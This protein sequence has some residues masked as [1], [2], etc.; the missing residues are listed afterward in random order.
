MN[1]QSHITT[2]ADVKAFFH[3][4][5][6]ERKL[7]FHPDDDFADYISVKEGTPTFTNEEVTVYNRLME[8][9]F[10]VCDA[11]G[12]DIYELGFEELQTIVKPAEAL[13]RLIM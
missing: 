9:S 5:V 2:V 8:E 3:H 10:D 6:D 13:S 7:N 1:K 12:V 11:A 4:L